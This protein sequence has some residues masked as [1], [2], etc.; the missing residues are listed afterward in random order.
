MFRRIKFLTLL[1]LLGVFLIP[2]AHAGDLFKEYLHGCWAFNVQS[3]STLK[4]ETIE[5][6]KNGTFECTRAGRTEVVGFW[7]LV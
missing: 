3:G 7:S 5:F 1:V 2:R 6:H 4:S